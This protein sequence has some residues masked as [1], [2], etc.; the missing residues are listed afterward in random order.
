MAKAK[1]ETAAELVTRFNSSADLG[2]AVLKDKKIY[3][4]GKSIPSHK[5]EGSGVIG[6]LDA[7]KSKVVGEH[8]RFTTKAGVAKLTELLGE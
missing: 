5:I 2:T 4:I 1:K 3:L 7:E 8:A 6:M